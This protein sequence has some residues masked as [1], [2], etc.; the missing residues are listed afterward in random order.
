MLLIGE[1]SAAFLA[2]A[3][4]RL[5]VL[6]GEDIAIPGRRPSRC[7]RE[8][9]GARVCRRLGLRAPETILAIHPTLGRIAI[10]EFVHHADPVGEDELRSLRTLPEGRRLL[11][12]DLVCANPDRRA[13]NL[14]RAD[15]RYVPVDFEAGFSG[16]P[17][18]QVIDRWF[19]VEA[20]LDLRPRDR[21][22]LGA[23]AERAQRLLTPSFLRRAVEGIPPEFL[24]GDERRRV[25]EGTV[26]RARAAR[27][28]LDTWWWRC[29]E[30]AHRLL[31]EGA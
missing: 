16:T 14:L 22:L 17:P 1:T 21:L 7:Y 9:L 25:Q 13:A 8:Y 15:D 18:S 12:A 31:G 11:I 3:D 23:E 5:S 19:G 4:D 24:S 26:S 6:R 10:Q 28:E 29:V 27:H 20:L 2:R 30:P